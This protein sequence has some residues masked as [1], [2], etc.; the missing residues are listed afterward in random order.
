MRLTLLVLVPE[1][2]GAFTGITLTS[3]LNQFRDPHPQQ[4][5]F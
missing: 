5:S 1:I 4:L 3:R 2:R